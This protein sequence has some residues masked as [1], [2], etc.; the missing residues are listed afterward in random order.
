MSSDDQLTIQLLILLQVI[1]DLSHSTKQNRKLANLSNV[2]YLGISTKALKKKKNNTPESKY[3][4]LNFSS[5]IAH[6]C[7]P[8]FITPFFVFPDTDKIRLTPTTRIPGKIAMS[9]QGVYTFQKVN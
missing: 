4:G 1:S 7:D 2:T 6:R 9:G 3:L 8:R 5:F